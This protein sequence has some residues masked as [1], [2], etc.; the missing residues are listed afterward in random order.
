MHGVL[1]KVKYVGHEKVAVNDDD[2]HNITFI[3]DD[4]LAL[5]MVDDQSGKSFYRIVKRVH[6]QES[7]LRRVAGH[8]LRRTHN[9]EK[10]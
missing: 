10:H 1:A 8:F 2:V 3:N 4:L 9:E 6:D 5:E 7:H